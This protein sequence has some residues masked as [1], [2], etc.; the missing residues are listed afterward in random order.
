MQ[1]RAKRLELRIERVRSP[2]TE[3]DR[4][5]ESLAGVT[6]QRVGFG[7]R[8]LR[9]EDELCARRRSVGDKLEQTVEIALRGPN[10]RHG[11]LRE[12]KLPLEAQTRLEHGTTD[13]RERRREVARVGLR[14]EACEQARGPQLARDQRVDATCPLVS[15]P[16]VQRDRAIVRRSRSALVPLVGVH[17][18][19]KPGARDGGVDVPETLRDVMAT[20]RSSSPVTAL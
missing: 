12:P 1:R 20:S 4:I 15:P 5:V 2:P 18:G 17:G 7:E 13:V 9:G 16:R 10:H 8:G 11:P 19:N 14:L 6:V 3:G